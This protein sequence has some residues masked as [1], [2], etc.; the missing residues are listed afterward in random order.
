MDNE[1]AY[2]NFL[3]HIHVGGGL[4]WD[5]YELSLELSKNDHTIRIVF[6]IV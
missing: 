6:R 5:K 3:F 4:K 1:K 2:V